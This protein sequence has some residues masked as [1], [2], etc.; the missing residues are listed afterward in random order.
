MSS[1]SQDQAGG[2]APVSIST[3]SLHSTN[4]KSKFPDCFPSLNPVDVYRQHIGE[5]LGQVTGIDPVKIYQRLAWTNTLDKG[6]LSLPV[7]MITR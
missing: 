5:S 3:L 4:E 6:D 1:T 2:E 7:S